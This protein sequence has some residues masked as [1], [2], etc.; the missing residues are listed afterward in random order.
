MWGLL[1]IFAAVVGVAWHTPHC[2]VQIQGPF[3][4]A[5]GCKSEGDRLQLDMCS[6]MS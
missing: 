2:Q 6:G 1:K 5:L 3:S 4:S